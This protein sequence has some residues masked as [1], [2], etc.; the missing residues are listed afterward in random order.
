MIPKTKIFVGKLPENCSEAELRKL[1]EQHGEVTECSVMGN[2]AFVHMKTEEQAD[3]AIRTLNNYSFE[4]SNLNVEAS[5]GERKRGGMR[6]GGFRGGRGGRG[7]FDGGW[8]GGFRGRGRG[9]FRGGRGGGPM[10]GG[11]RGRMGPYDRYDAPRG[12][13]GEDYGRRDDYRA[14]MP[15]RDP[16]D[17]SAR[18]PYVT[19]VARDPYD[20]APRDPYAAPV[21][22]DPYAAD[23]RDP[24]APPPARDP[25]A[26]VA[27]DPYAAPARDPYAAPPRDPYA[28][29]PPPPPVRDY[30]SYDTYGARR[31]PP[32][33]AAYD[34]RPADSYSA[35]SSYSS[36]PPRRY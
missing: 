17:V 7:G 21:P 23:P 33:V 4:G 35:Y 22:R 12:G 14:P 36:A 34:R 31:T 8:G 28:A 27:R 24:Y 25:Y 1:F 32:P 29:A 20:V 26:P 19:P 6:G 11:M 13:Y 3:D 9:D 15:P 30:E 2:F 5:T 10:R 16:Y 18:D